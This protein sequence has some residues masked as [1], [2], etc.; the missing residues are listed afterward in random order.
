MSMPA[1]EPTARDVPSLPAARWATRTHFF[2]SGFLFA[3]WGVHIPTVKAHYEIGEGALGLAL[4]AAGI[5]ALLGLSRAGTLVGRFGAKGV[6]L[7]CGVASA[8]ML[9]L[10]LILPGYA[11][12]LAALAVFGG[13]SSIFDVAINAEASEL[14]R[15]QARPIMSHFHAMF[16]LGGMA[17]AAI[18]SLLLGWQVDAMSHLVGV[19]VAGALA[20]GAACLQM[21][22]PEQAGEDAGFSLPRGALLL[23]GVLAALGLISEGAMY[24]WSVLYLQNELGSPQDQAALA[25][26]S[27]SGAM[28]LARFA[29]DWVRSR[30]SPATLMRASAA[31]SAAAM[32]LVLLVGHPGV[33]LVGFAFVGVGLGNVVPVLFSAAAHV[34][35]TSPAHGI[36]AVSSVGYLG[37]MAGPPLIGVLAQGS[38]LTA[39]LFVVVLF[40]AVLAG[41][42]RRALPR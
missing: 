23:L 22:P 18:G 34:P 7:V 37:F 31:L 19:A 9:G 10:L 29:G 32:A 42:S 13:A 28:A 5:G 35:G 36:A 12:L 30:T 38:S 11:G 26:A 2:C 8:A 15:R 17:G 14:E 25:Y 27:F 40:T 6:A 20:I 33:A 1:S 16:S 39:A 21:L 41:L 24:D 4:L 3:T